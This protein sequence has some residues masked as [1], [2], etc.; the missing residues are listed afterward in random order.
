MTRILKII[1]A[2]AA[3][4]VLAGVVIHFANRAAP[5]PEAVIAIVETRPLLES[6]TPAEREKSIRAVAERMS[7]LDWDQRRV[8]RRSETFQAYVESM[9]E[10]EMS[11]FLDLTLP[12]GFRQMMLALNKM[13]PERR[14]QIVERALADIEQADTEAGPEGR[15]RRQFTA[16]DPNARKIIAE[17]MS[18]FYEDASVDVKL[19]FAPVLERIQGRLQWQ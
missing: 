4:W 15:G 14:Q 17:G 16:D 10:D 19:D 11:E 12:E 5:S 8:L 9:S 3:V 7:R 18:A 1:A 6:T 2:V 13:T